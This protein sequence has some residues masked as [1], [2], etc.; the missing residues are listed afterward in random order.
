MTNEL[1]IEVSKLTRISRRLSTEFG[2]RNDM[3]PD[4]KVCRDCYISAL[5][6]KFEDSRKKLLPQQ[7]KKKIAEVNML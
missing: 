2:S 5:G 3:P 1:V 4:H 7:K 6:D